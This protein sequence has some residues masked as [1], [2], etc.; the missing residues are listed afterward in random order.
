MAEPNTSNRNAK[1]FNGHPSW[2]CWNVFLHISNNE[3]TYLEGIHL[4]ASH[5]LT[6]ATEILYM[7]IG[8]SK[9]PDCA[10]YTRRSIRH[11]LHCLTDE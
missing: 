9:T 7:R 11:A 1:P 4:V 6:Q 10:V 5:S 2:A 8:G 3:T